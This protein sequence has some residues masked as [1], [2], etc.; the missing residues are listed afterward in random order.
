MKEFN[1]L[2]ERDDVND[3]YISK[4]GCFMYPDFDLF[5]DNPQTIIIFTRTICDSETHQIF[6]TPDGANTMYL[7]DGCFM[8]VL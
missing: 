2:N 1:M 7:D 5:G 4:M 6:V 3:V 8:Y